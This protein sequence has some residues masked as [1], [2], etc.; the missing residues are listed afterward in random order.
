[1]LVVR[2]YFS[3]RKEKQNARETLAG[4]KFAYLF[5]KYVSSSLPSLFSCAHYSGDS[6]DNSVW[7][8]RTV[9]KCAKKIGAGFDGVNR[10]AKLGS[11][12]SEAI[13]KFIIFVS[14]VAAR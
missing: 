9:L 5:I 14:V 13:I 12:H 1:M 3:G 2:K 8:A 11:T 7:D 4:R 10:R 6:N